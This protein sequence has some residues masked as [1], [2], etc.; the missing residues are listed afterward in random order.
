MSESDCPPP[1]RD[2]QRLRRSGHRAGLSLLIGR[3]FC[4]AR[5]GVARGL[6]A[7]GFTPNLVTTTGFVFTLAAGWC[8]AQGAGHQVP[9]FYDGQGPVSY[10]PLWA[11]LLLIGSGACDMLDGAVARVGN[12]ASPFGA[13]LDSTLDR[14]SDM[15]IFIGCA[16]YYWRAGDASWFVPIAAL[17][18]AFMI[19][20]IKARAENVIPD[21]AVGYWL[22]GERFAAVLIGCLCGHVIAALW[23]LAV[24]A[25]FTVLRRFVYAWQ[26]V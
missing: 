25:A 24:L 10:W 9:Y 13:V 22:R 17:C 19:S 26:A 5:D 7:V 3:G 18:N 15:A 4:A 2:F 6:I 8:L 1:G 12:L 23:L 21:C 16:T 14:L 20:Y 11:A